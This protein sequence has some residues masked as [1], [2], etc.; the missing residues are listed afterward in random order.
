MSASEFPMDRL[1]VAMVTP[2]DAAGRIDEAELR[3]L[4]DYFLQPEYVAAGIAI[5]ANP[6]A[7]EVFY[8][9]PE[10]QD[11]VLATTV[12]AVAGRTPVLAGVCALTTAGAVDAARR[13]ASAGADGLFVLPPIGTQDITTCWDAVSYPEIWVDMVRAIAD[14]TPDLPMVLH[15]VA[16]L[17]M[18]YGVGLPVEATLA[19]LDEIPQIAGWK[20]TYA[21]Q[22]YRLIAR[23]LR[24]YPRHVGVLGAMGVHFHEYLAN[25]YFDGT[26]SGSFNYALE[27]HVEHIAAWRAGDIALA[28]QIWADG[29]A[30][31]GEYIYSEFTRLHIRYKTAAW[32]RGLISLPFMRA[33][34]PQPRAAEVARL[35]RLLRGAGY[36]LRPDAEI[37]PIVAG[38][39]P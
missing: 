36:E 7:G 15:P 34:L 1:W 8:L 39:R 17:S 32:L 20:M 18:V 25:G 10:E 37:K 31:L 5:I 13:A 29:L 30:E 33:P 27:R 22:G 11:L 2:Q 28:Q 12:Q 3:Q 21:Y 26:A 38:L 9:T 19:M 23:T 4:V 14:A 35:Q 6:E 24:N 16:S